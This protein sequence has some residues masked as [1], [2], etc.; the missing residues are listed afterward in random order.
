MHTPVL[1][2][3]ILEILNPVSGETVVDGTFGAGGHA[4]LFI[5]RIGSTGSFLGVDWS[6]EAV[7]LGKKICEEKKHCAVVQGNYVDLPG[8]L[9]KLRFPKP[10]VLL[11]DLG[12]STEELEESGRGF[13]FKR[14]ELLDMRY[15]PN[16][17]RTTAAEWVNRLPEK[18]LSDML[19]KFGEEKFAPRIAQAIVEARHGKRIMRTSELVECI[20][21]TVPQSQLHGRIHPATRTFQA[22]R[23]YVNDELENIKRILRVLPEMMAAGGRAGIISFHSLED[24]LVKNE[25]RDFSKK[26]AATVLTKKPVSASRDEI[27]FNPRSRS[28]KFR[29]I[30]F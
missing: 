17:E 4:R 8:L 22:L 5:E 27:D 13:S 15:S 12:L 14:D 26:S 19:Y 29:A 21:G 24:R 20:L 16:P 28:A 2:K 6:S 7:A 9:H 23:I 10:D 1:S 30:Q 25:F 18:E 3:E 11:L